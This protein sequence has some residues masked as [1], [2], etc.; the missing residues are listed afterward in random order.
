MEQDLK[1]RQIE[2]KLNSGNAQMKDVITVFLALQKQNFILSNSIL[3]LL[4][5]WPNE[6]H[7]FIDA[8]K[9]IPIKIQIKE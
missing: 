6:N 4:E 3:N 5:N 8:S 7:L 1:L 2:L 9:G